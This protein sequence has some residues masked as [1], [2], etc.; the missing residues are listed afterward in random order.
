MNSRNNIPYCGRGAR[1]ICAPGATWSRRVARLGTGPLA[2]GVGGDLVD[3][4]LGLPQ[5]FLA[6]PLQ[7]FAALVDGH[8]FLQRHLAVF[9]PLDDRFNLLDRALEAQLFD[10]DLAVSLGIFRHIA[11]PYAP[12]VPART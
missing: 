5:Q 2:V 1:W 3:P 11:F 6:A 10:V 4:R 7:G 9:E 12:L 8:R